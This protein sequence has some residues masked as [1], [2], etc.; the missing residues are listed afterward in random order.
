MKRISV[1]GLLAAFVLTLAA[2]GISKA[3]VLEDTPPRD[4]FFEN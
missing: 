1:I 3:Q 2:Q 4:N